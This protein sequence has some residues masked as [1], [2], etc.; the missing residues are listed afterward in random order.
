ML[1]RLFQCQK[2]VPADFAGTRTGLIGPA[3]RTAVAPLKRT[4]KSSSRVHPIQIP[5]KGHLW[6]TTASLQGEMSC[7]QTRNRDFARFPQ[8]QIRLARCRRD[9]LRSF[10]RTFLNLD[11]RFRTGFSDVPKHAELFIWGASAFGRAFE[12]AWN[13]RGKSPKL[14]G[15]AEIN[16][17]AGRGKRSDCRNNQ[18]RNFI[19]FSHETF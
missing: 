13:V 19:I 9:A 1:S 3:C 17:C 5:V 15:G 11:P 18:P 7:L 4:W 8:R 14:R 2:D 16:S 6:R 10:R 12:E